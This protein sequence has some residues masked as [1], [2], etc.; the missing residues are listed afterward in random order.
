MITVAKTVLIQANEKDIWRIVADVGDVHKFHPM[1]DTSPVLSTE[2][3][4]MGATRRCEFYDG[5]SVVEKVVEW[6]EGKKMKL[7]LSEFS[8]PFKYAVVT[9]SLESAGANSTY[10]T[11]EMEFMVKFGVFG[12]ILGYLMMRPA[13]KMV[14]G[15]VLKGLN[16]HA[17]TGQLVGQKGVLSQAA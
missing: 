3:Q 4:G 8:M 11:I 7:E 2:F 15:K 16:D 13:M 6:K 12:K 9:M 5:T 1:V 14:F 17:T 10:V